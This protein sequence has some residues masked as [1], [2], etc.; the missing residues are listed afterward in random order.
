MTK[1]IDR[2]LEKLEEKR[3]DS[4]GSYVTS[5]I[6]YGSVIDALE[7]VRD[8]MKEREER[9]EELEDNKN[10]GRAGIKLSDN[11][12]RP[13][14]GLP[15]RRTSPGGASVSPRT[16]DPSHATCA[17]SVTVLR[18]LSSVSRQVSPA[19]GGA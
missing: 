11:S 12:G 5:G 16:T 3:E 7:A 8:D 14:N 1:K 17:P 4:D 2:V 18:R 10:R 15:Q 9:V 13:E 19:P 6:L